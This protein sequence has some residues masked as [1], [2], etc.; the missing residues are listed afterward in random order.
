MNDYSVDRAGRRPHSEQESK[1]WDSLQEN[2]RRK[3]EK[4]KHETWRR[5]YN[6][7][8]EAI[9]VECYKTKPL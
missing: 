7:T 5:S 8:P 2:M 9:C 3:Q 6:V 4:C 1:N